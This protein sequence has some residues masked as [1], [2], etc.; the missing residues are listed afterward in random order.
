MNIIK[1]AYM[2]ELSNT[3]IEQIQSNVTPSM[4]SYDESTCQYYISQVL[5]TLK[6][7]DSNEFDIALIEELVD[8]GISFIEI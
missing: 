8:L 1:V 5:E 4:I 3:S 7:Y 6:Y 2:P